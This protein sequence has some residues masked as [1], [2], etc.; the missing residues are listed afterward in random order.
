MPATIQEAIC[1]PSLV[2]LHHRTA[3]VVGG[4]PPLIMV[5][6]SSDIG[7]VC[8]SSAPRS[9]RRSTTQITPTSDAVDGDDDECRRRRSASHTVN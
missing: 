2:N 6:S 4:T 3:R 9:F 1:R 7:V 8:T 5:V